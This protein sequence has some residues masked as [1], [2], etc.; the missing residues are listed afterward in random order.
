MS[1]TEEV[2]RYFSIGSNSGSSSGAK[3][4]A[5][6]FVSIEERNLKAYSHEDKDDIKF[7]FLEDEW[8]DMTADEAIELV[9]HLPPTVWG[10]K[11]KD[12]NFESELVEAVIEHVKTTESTTK[13]DLYLRREKSRR[14]RGGGKGND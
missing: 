13:L 1:D 2:N 11:I 8:K 12:A 3:L 4:G 9:K 7:D 6:K 10:L 5:R 14:R